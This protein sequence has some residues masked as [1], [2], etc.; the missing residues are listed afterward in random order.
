MLPQSLHQPWRTT[1]G[2]LVDLGEVL[3][4]NTADGAAEVRRE[5]LVGG[6]VDVAADVAAE[7]VLGR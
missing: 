5:L 2:T 7:V 4:A 3:G 6:L 1:G